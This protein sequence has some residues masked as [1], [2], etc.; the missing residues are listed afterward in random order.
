MSLLVSELIMGLDEI[1][2]FSDLIMFFGDE[3]FD[4][5]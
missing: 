1:K 4:Q 2:L 3:V 5:S